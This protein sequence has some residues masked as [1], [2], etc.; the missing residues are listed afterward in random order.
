[1]RARIIR[2]FTVPAGIPN[3]RAASRV[4]SPSRIVAWTTARSST[5]KL[6][7]APARSPWATPNN[8]T[9]SAVVNV[10]ASDTR[11]ETGDQRDR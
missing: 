11:F 3:R 6:S 4:V 7:I 9:S 10:V 1:M 2:V 5:G 8:T